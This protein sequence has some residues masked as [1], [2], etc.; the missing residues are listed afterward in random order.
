METGRKRESGEVHLVGVILMVVLVIGIVLIVQSFAMGTTSQLH[1][2]VYIAS[3]AGVKEVI[4]ASGPPV[5]VVALTIREAEPFHFEGQPAPAPGKVVRIK[6]MS[7]DGRTLYPE[8]FLSSGSLEG[9]TLFIYPNSSSYSGYCDYIVSE[10]LPNGKLKPLTMGTWVVQLIDPEIPLLISSDDRA[11]ITSGT[12]SYPLAGGTAGG[13][14]WRTDCTPL[15]YSV[16]GNPVTGFTGVPMNMTYL[17][18]DGDD[19]L[20]YADDPTLT[21]TGDLTLSVWLQPTTVG[22]WMQVLGKGLQTNQGGQITE[23][24]NYDL[25]LINGKVYFEWDDRVTN[26]HYHVMTDNVAVTANNWNYVDLVV[27]GGTPTI[28]VNGVSQTY[29]YYQS[30]VP[31]TNKITSPSQIP[32]VRLKDNDHPLTMGRQASTQYPFYYSGSIGSFALY[33]RGLTQGEITGNY[34]NYL[35]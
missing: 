7:P 1:S 22:S 3:E 4:Q 11:V 9:R 23:D 16:N 27:E 12:T 26:T 20:S 31:G 28:Y 8:P 34:Q 18:F 14:V 32:D 30:N 10:T 19:W 6:V 24:K 15:S 2:T 17:R 21:Y 33:N 35:A 5:Q 25:Y 13:D 29:S